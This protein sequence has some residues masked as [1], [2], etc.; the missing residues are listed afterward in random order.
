MFS[1]SL[2]SFLFYSPSF[3][4]SLSQTHP[5]M[6]PWFCFVMVLHSMLGE[7]SPRLTFRIWR[8]EVCPGDTKPSVA[9]PKTDFS[10]LGSNHGVDHISQPATG[11]DF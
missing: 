6:L 1:V 8:C 3:S 11:L 5:F 4:L 2:T 10:R 7:G 9:T